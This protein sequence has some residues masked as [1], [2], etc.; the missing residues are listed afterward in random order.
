V[1]EV[2]ELAI[3]ADGDALAATFRAARE[4]AMPWLPKLHTE[5]EDRRFFE[6]RVLAECEVLVVRRSGAPAGFLALK[7]DMVEHLYVHPEAQREGI[8]SALL[9]AAKARRPN[10][11]RLWV[12]E[13][14]SGARAFYARHGFTEVRRTDGSGNEEREPDVLLAWRG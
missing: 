12:F 3:A 5:A 10:G 2:I 7:D 11:L 9:D 6:E 8:G 13:R 4:A 14:N 1:A